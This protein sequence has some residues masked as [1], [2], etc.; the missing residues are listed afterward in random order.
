M[1]SAYSVLGVPGNASRSDI[2]AAFEKARIYYSPPKLADDTVAVDKFIELKDAYNVLRDADSR[3]AHDRKLNSARN[4]PTTAN[5]SSRMLRTVEI[6][7]EPA[8][9]TRPLP[10]LAVV[11]VLIFAFGFYVNQK[12]VAAG[13]EQAAKELQL[14]IIAEKEAEKESAQLE[15]EAAAKTLLA[16]KNEQQDRQFR[17][18]SER[19]IDNAR[20]DEM[21]RG[22][23]DT[24]REAMAQQAA[25]RRD[26]D[27][28]A[29]EQS[30]AR[31]AQQRLAADKAR[32][33]ELCYQNY[34]RS[35][36]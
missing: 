33:R 5:A 17:Q 9:F 14:K 35:D 25:T 4:L 24:Q 23:L 20:R 18:E 30:L 2:E 10:V 7:A 11:V 21:Q 34:R 3:A 27:A 31:E 32:I 29:R 16:R 26:S 15:K 22:Y 12:R 1:K 8:W 19:A 36:C 6:D 28:R 13:K